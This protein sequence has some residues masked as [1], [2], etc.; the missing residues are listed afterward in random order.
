MKTMWECVSAYLVIM[1]S[2]VLKRSHP[3][4]LAQSLLRR[5]LYFK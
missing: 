2:E 3:P 4:Q 5:M 1:D